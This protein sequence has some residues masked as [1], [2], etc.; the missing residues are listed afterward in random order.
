MYVH[1]NAPMIPIDLMHYVIQWAHDVADAGYIIRSSIFHAMYNPTSWGSYANDNLLATW[2]SVANGSFAAIFGDTE[3]VPIE[4]GGNDAPFSDA[5]W[6]IECGDARDPEDGLTLRSI[7]DEML[8]VSHEVSGYC[9]CCYMLILRNI[10]DKWFQLV[11]HRYR[12]DM[13]RQF[14][15]IVQSRGSMVLSTAH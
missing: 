3:N 10:A 15:L 4:Y 14:G 13:W 2:L 12:Q 6:A 8:R 1:F 11:V 5:Q 7:F 9:A